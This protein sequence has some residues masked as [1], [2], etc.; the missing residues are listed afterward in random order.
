M[1]NLYQTTNN[2]CAKPERTKHKSFI[3]KDDDNSGRVNP[4]ISWC[5]ADV[6]ISNKISPDEKWIPNKILKLCNWRLYFPLSDGNL[7]QTDE[8]LGKILWRSRQRQRGLEHL[9]QK[10][11]LTDHKRGAL[12]I[13]ME[14]TRQR[15]RQHRRPLCCAIETMKIPTSVSWCNDKL[16][17]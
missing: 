1:K 14:H 2:W 12:P 15:W 7:V 10:T 4:Y 5:H 8:K 9:K 6:F 16:L 11:M 17:H 13:N 3:T